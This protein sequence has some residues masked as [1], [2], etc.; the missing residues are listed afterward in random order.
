[1][2]LCYN[3]VMIRFQGTHE[4]FG[5]YQAFK[6]AKANHDFCTHANAGTLKKQLVIYEKFYP[7]LVLEI[8]AMAKWLKMSED[9]LLYDEIGLFLD[10]WRNRIEAARV[11]RKSL[12]ALQACTI[13][14]I[15]EAGQVFVGRNYDWLPAARE[16]FERYDLELTGAKKYFGFSDE[17]VWGRHVGKSSRKVYI[18]DA[19]NES[20]LYIGLTFSHIEKFNYGLNPMHL[21]R[22][23]AEKAA[24]TRQALNIFAKVPCAIP[25]NF[26]I[27]D[28]KGDLAV[29]EHAATDY[30]IV[31]PDEYGVLVQTNH[32]L[33]PKLQKFDRVLRDDPQ[34]ST[35]VRRAEANFLIQQEMPGFQFT[36]LARILR[37][38]RYVYNEETIWSL[39]LELTQQRFNVYYDT[40]NGEKHTKF[41]FTKK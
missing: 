11:R 17:G 34:A 23:V 21:I 24:T 15:R 4:E 29:V 7:E 33:A 40:A 32:I 31:R 5:C 28:A 6:L 38:S 26:L 36:D 35:F 37:K 3:K 20:G 27:A 2:K 30:E 41:G 12:P 8:R 10:A 13:F 9:I 25:K 39:A 18:V 1:M 19:V 16:F 22:L 14:A